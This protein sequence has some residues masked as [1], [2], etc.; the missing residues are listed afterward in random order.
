[1]SFTR[2]TALAAMI[3]CVGAAAVAQD[4][5]KPDWT[6]SPWGA[7][8]ELGAAN[9]MTPERVKSAA[10]LVTTGKVYSLG[11]VVGPD[12]PAF[13]P[14]S[15][16]VTVLQPNQVSTSGLGENAFTYN[17]D[18]F[19]GWLG[20]GSQIDGL[21]H[22]GVDHMYYNGHTDDEFAGA[23][24]LSKLGLE[25]L[26]GLVG[27]GVMLDM[28]K[29]FD[30]EMVASGTPYTEEDVKAAAEAQGVSI[31]E[32]DI[33]LFNS[34]WMNLL[35]GD[36]AD[37]ARFGSA[38][39]GLGVSGAEYLASLGVMAVGADTWGMEVVPAEKEGEAFRAHQIL[40]PEHGIYIL[41]NMDTR[42]LAADGVH[43][44]LFVMGQARIQGA[45]QM[46]INPI[47]IR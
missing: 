15:L 11:M 28:A 30:V 47:A 12:T 13:A 41:E 6:E 3:S 20:I 34:N 27:R 25:K 23:A 7:E 40:Q 9:T 37:P 38:E 1:M 24:G 8:D 39:P 42:E 4:N 26:P 43:E 17:D 10:E 21:G 33:V 18:I 29:H 19:M 44:F 45:V 14:R 16:S 22:A 2:T 46:I 36:D 32:G 31:G 5:T 35:D